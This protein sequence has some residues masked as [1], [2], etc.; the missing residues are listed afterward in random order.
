MILRLRGETHRG[1]AIDLRD[2]RVDPAGLV[3]AIRAA[4]D[5]IVAAPPPG[6]VHEH[7]G[8]LHPGMDCAPRAALASAAR[9]RGRT[10]SYDERI[11]TLEA[12]IAAIDV[13]HVDLT[14]YQREV[15]TA[16]EDVAALRERV[17]TL[18]GRVQ[19]DREAGRDA[20]AVERDLRE[21][22]AALSEAETDQLAAEQALAEAERAARRARDAR[23]RRLSLVDRRDNLR[24]RAREQLVADARSRFREALRALPVDSP[25]SQGSDPLTAGDVP[26]LHAALAIARM[27]RV[28]A[29]L[30]VAAPFPSA[31]AARAA[32]DA[33][34]LLV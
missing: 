33:P 6:P 21:T 11:A 28:R 32:L 18:R 8:W 14:P 27:A 13:D 20:T 26:P 3:R 10:T 15:A 9:S 25:P 4:T 5:A 1:Q 29:P 7:V 22:V 34:V 31:T 2:S 23:E 17:A 19:A 30:V 12:D 24:R 16:G